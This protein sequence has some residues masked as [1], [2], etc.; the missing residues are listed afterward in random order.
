MWKKILGPKK[1]VGLKKMAPKRIVGRKTS[2]KLHD[3]EAIE[4]EIWKYQGSL[5]KSL[6]CQALRKCR[7][8]IRKL[9]ENDEKLHW[10]SMETIEKTVH[11]L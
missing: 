9:W 6:G 7:E 4:I 1:K 11:K 2:M 5:K 10:N 8:K 3:C